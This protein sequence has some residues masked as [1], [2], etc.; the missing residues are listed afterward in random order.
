MRREKFAQHS[1]FHTNRLYSNRV[2]Y[3]NNG[4]EELGKVGVG[5]CF[6]TVGATKSFT[7]ADLKVTGYPST[8]CSGKFII[9]KLETDGSA[10]TANCY[11]WWDDASHEAGW[12]NRTGKTKIEEEKVGFQQGQGFWTDGKGYKL[13]SSGQ[14]TTETIVCDTETL[15]KVM[16]T[17]ATPVALALKDLTVTGYP[18]TGCSG[19]FIIQKLETDGSALTA[20]CY[21]WWDDASHTAGWYNRTGKTALDAENIPAPAGTAFW[22]DGKG[23]KLVLPKV[24]IQ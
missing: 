19:K 10:L 17:Q 12:Y 20:N 4:T 24:D 16:I 11:Y 5:P 3:L 2:G 7:L 8:G 23:Y 15:G 18:T 6:A 21:Y 1:V 14:V 9:Q 13:V 22:V